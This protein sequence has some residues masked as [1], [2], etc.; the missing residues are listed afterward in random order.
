MIRGKEHNFLAQL[1]P[2]IIPFRRQYNNG[3]IFYKTYAR[4]HINC[5]CALKHNSA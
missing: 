3:V 2:K 5:K 4:A 1:N